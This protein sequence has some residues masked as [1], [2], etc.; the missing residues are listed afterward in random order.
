MCSFVAW[1][2]RSDENLICG[3]CIGIRGER[4]K[5]LR[6]QCLGAF[7]VSALTERWVAPG[8]FVGRGSAG[9]S[10]TPFSEPQGAPLNRF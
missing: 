3:Q 7:P 8:V 2:A 4:D 6:G 9:R 10:T 5:L 1:F